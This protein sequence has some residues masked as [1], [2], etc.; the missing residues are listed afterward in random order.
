MYNIENISY[1]AK[2]NPEWFTKALFSGKIISDKYVTIIPNVKN[3]ILLSDVNI[4]GN[5]LQKDNG[6]CGWN[7]NGEIQ[8]SER[9][10]KVETYKIQLEDCI[11]KLKQNGLL[12]F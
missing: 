10:L 9:E 1:Q 12:N 4:S 2:R 8:L 5:L 6:D 3:S 7:P 11:D